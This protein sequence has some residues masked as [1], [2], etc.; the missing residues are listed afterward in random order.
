[1]DLR[2]EEFFGGVPD[3][4]SEALALADDVGVCTSALS[5]AMWRTSQ[6]GENCYLLTA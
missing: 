5:A 2:V 1:M 6:N 4:S 3:A